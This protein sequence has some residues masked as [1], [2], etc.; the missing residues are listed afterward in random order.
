MLLARYFISGY[1]VRG[2]GLGSE[3]LSG[4]SVHMNGILVSDGMLAIF[5]E[6]P[7]DT[8]TDAILAMVSE[9]PTG[10]G[11]VAPAVKHLVG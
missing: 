8:G 3:R 5:S 7:T 2:V 10:M 4:G 11:S 6:A 9:G 1:V